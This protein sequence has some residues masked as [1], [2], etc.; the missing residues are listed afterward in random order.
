MNK[1][2][3]IAALLSLAAWAAP[4]WAQTPPASAPLAQSALNAGFERSLQHYENNQWL[5]AFALL[6]ELAD[7]G[8]PE[9]TRLALQMWRYGPSLYGQRFDLGDGRRARW[10][11]GATPALMADSGR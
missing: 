3:L 6:A 11:A 4:V 1:L 7:Q 8:H 5:A 2:N 10:L 9:A